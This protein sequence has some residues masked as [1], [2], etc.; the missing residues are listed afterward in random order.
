MSPAITK[1]KTAPIISPAKI[2]GYV[3]EIL[4]YSL[5]L[6]RWAFLRKPPKRVNPTRAEQPKLTVLLTTPFVCPAYSK[7][8]AVSLS[9]YDIFAIL[10]DV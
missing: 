4:A 5:E 1:G 2:S 9:S 8:E 6:S 3:R 7:H 10:A